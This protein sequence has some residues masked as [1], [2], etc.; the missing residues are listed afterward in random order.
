MSRFKAHGVSHIGYKRER[1]EDRW[2][3]LDHIPFFAVAD[4]MGG[5]KAGAVA[6]NET[7]EHLKQSIETLNKISPLTDLSPESLALF[8][9]K[10]IKN[11]NTWIHHLSNQNGD[12]QGMGTTL[13]C[14]L[15]HEDFLIYGHVGDSR[16]YH[17]NQE[18]NLLTQ[19]H[20]K[21]HLKER[22]SSSLRKSHTLTRAIGPYPHVIPDIGVQKLLPTDTY[23]FCSDGL[24]DYVCEEEIKNV[25]KSAA[26]LAEKNETLLKA[27]LSY[28][29]KDNITSLLFQLNS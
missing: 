29:G 10:A 5:H 20:I 18:L 7:I 23:L 21:P 25:L 26:S 14:A 28:G 4:G 17:F 13:A 27:A 1:N 16:L 8:L 19:D 11:A 2:A 9:K 15:L 3:I 12:H 22:T 6:S 24:T